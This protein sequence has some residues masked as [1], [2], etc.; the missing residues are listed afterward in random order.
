MIVLGKVSEHER[1]PGGETE[2]FFTM[3]KLV[4]FS[5]VVDGWKKV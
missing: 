4:K 1:L 3:E 2:N 5:Q